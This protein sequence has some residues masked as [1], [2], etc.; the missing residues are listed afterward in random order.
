V[1]T[2]RAGIAI[3]DEARR[4]GVEAMVL[5]AEEPS[6]IRGGA[7]LGGRGGRLE[8]FVG[9]VTKYVVNKAPCRVIVTAP[10]ARDGEAKPERSL[11]TTRA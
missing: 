2:R 8:N 6:L 10:P 11:S 7:R 5:G 9:D 1:R 4:R 3:V